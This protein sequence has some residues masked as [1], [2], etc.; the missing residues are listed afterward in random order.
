MIEDIEFIKKRGQEFFEVALESFNKRRYNI[1]ILHIEQALQCF[2]KYLLGLRAGE[3]PKTHL[4]TLLLDEVIKIYKLKKFKKIYKDKILEIRELEDAY[5]TSRYVN[6]EYKKEDIEKALETF[7]L[8]IKTLENET[9]IQLIS[10]P[11]KK[12]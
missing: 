5:I 10:K 1:S 4:L 8:I 2:L 11:S 6:K 12:I 9:K 3:W 7:Y